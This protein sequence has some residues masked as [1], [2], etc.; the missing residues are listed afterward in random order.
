MLAFLTSSQNLNLL[1]Q[2]PYTENHCSSMEDIWAYTVIR[3]QR[4]DQNVNLPVPRMGLVYVHSMT[5]LRPLLTDFPKNCPG[6]YFNESYEQPNYFRVTSRG[7]FLQRR[8]KLL[9][10]ESC[11]L[12]PVHVSLFLQVGNWVLCWVWV[13][14]FLVRKTGPEQTSIP[15]LPLFAWGRF[16]LS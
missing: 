15:N 2:G 3:C 7:Y 13:A 8:K 5:F 11:G 9:L 4:K 16:T 14:F 1:V 10:L 12:I 6:V